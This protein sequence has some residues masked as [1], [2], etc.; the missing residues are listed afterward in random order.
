MTRTRR[1]LTIIL[2][3]FSLLLVASAGF[4]ASRPDAAVHRAETESA[5]APEGGDDQGQDEQ[6]GDEETIGSD[7][8]NAA[9][10]TPVDPEREAACNE[11]AGVVPTDTGTTTGDATTD[12][13]TDEP[14]KIVGLDNA[15]A[16]VLANC[17]K[18]PDAP[19]LVNALQHLVANQAKHEAHDAAK[20]ERKAAHDAR[21]AEHG[22]GH[23]GSHGNPHADGGSGNP[24]GAGNGGGH[25][26]H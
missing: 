23:D 15:I 2:S 10:S 6:S 13:T 14:T 19:G 21:K 25:A 3:V 4:A 8:A 5:P 18:N 26:R 11:A 24:H 17:M 1:L 16:H 9:D 22:H 12:V 20:T 7:G